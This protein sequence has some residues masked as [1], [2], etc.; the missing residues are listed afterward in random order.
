MAML[1]RRSLSDVLIAAFVVGLVV[2][3]SMTGTLAATPDI[4]S[5]TA[6]CAALV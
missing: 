1:W 4:G 5:V 2:V 6:R 3:L